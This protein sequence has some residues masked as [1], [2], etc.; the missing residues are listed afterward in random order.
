MQLDNK[1]ALITGGTKGIGAATALLLAR[2]G[3]G[4][5]IVG[6]KEDDQAIKTR[7]TI[8]STGQ[9]CLM[10]AGD[11]SKAKDAVRCVNETKD[12]LGTLDI[13]VHCA[14]GNVAGKLTEV[15]PKAWYD[16]FD[17]HVHSVFH[18]CRAAIPIM[19]PKKEGAIVLIS[20][21]A[22]IRSLPTNL[23]Y[24]VVK[25]ALLQFT[26]GLARELA[27]DNI[28]VNAVAPGV[29]RTDFHKNM[30][31]EQKKI[32]LEQRI[33]LHREGTPA[34]VAA[35][36]SELIT[37]DYITGETVTIDGGLTMRIA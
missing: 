32:N 22:G 2:Q 18:L 5:T 16:G 13:I 17:T 36:I 25:G 29:I 8:E 1:I 35:L 21:V 6:R 20:S 23:G 11:M 26:R 14:G 31:A 24:Q 37:N 19:R 28:R 33:P 9:K 7:H 34:Q 30:T 3:A 4:V 15:S 27:D 10:I 12:R